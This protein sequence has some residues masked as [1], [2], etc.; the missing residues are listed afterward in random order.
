MKFI[1]KVSFMADEMIVQSNT[2]LKIRLDLEDFPEL[3]MASNQDRLAY[4]LVNNGTSI[5]WEALDLELKANE[6]FYESHDR[7]ASVVESDWDRIDPVNNRNKNY[8]NLY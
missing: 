3:L 7:E 5:L 1:F 2:G 6:L 8:G 4:A